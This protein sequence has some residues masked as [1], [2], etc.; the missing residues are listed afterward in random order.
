MLILTRKLGETI[1]IGNEIKIT[2]LDVKGR[3]VRIGIDAPS[4][5]T[6]HREEVHQIIREQNI[7]AAQAGRDESIGGSLSHVWKRLKNSKED[8]E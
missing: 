3:Q 8:G 2:I 1:R 7:L 5:I 6:V 4:N